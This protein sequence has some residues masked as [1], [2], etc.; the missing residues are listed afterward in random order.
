MWCALA[1][2]FQLM[3]AFDALI[4]NTERNLGNL[5]WSRD[6]TMWMIDHTRAF[7][8]NDKVPTPATLI[9]CERALLSEMRSLTA[10]SIGAAV[11]SELSGVEISALLKRRDE[12]VA[13]FEARI[14]KQGEAAVLYSMKH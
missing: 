2:Q 1:P 13:H 14:T 8:L 7:R 3:Y 10:E 11:E 6:G 5:L 12:I 9:R 4:G